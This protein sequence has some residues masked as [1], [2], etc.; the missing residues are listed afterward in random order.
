MNSTPSARK[1]WCFTLRRQCHPTLF[2]KLEL[3]RQPY[4]GEILY[5]QTLRLF[6]ISTPLGIEE[7][8][9]ENLSATLFSAQ[10]QSDLSKQF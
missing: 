1:D 7:H 8:D 3:H 9:G 2:L 5:A 10:P 4:E 6:S